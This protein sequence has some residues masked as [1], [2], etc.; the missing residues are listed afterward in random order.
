[1]FLCLNEEESYDEFFDLQLA[2]V[3]KGDV[4]TL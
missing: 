4:D 1:M 2:T 3:T